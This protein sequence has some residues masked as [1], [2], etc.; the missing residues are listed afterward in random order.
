MTMVMRKFPL[1][2]FTEPKDGAHII[3][4]DR[5]WP[6][7]E[8]DEIFFFGRE[9]SPYSS[10][11]CNANKIIVDRHI[12]NPHVLRAA[13]GAEVEVRQLPVVYVPINWSDYAD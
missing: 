8:N 7:T 13:D 3:Y 12:R 4:L 6:V 9:N 5:W 2:N 10:P 11:Q 1:A